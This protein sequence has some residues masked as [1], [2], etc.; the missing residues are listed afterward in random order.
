MPVR[1]AKLFHRLSSGVP[2]SGPVSDG[3][4][5]TL[6]M[7]CGGLGRLLWECSMNRLSRLDIIFIEAPVYFITACTEKRRHLLANDDA[8]EV[9]R[10]F[11][12]LA[13]GRGVLVGRYVLMPDHLGGFAGALFE[14]QGDIT[15][16]VGSREDDDFSSLTYCVVYGHGPTRKRDQRRFLKRAMAVWHLG[17]RV[18]GMAHAPCSENGRGRRTGGEAPRR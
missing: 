3:R 17:P 18:H 14:S 2:A 4:R 15:V 6:Q 9:F 7:S 16:A 13:R 10:R 1:R 11:C 12:S 8:H 5:P